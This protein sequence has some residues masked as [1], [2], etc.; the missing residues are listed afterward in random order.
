MSWIENSIVFHFSLRSS[1]E[2]LIVLVEVL[3]QDRDFIPGDLDSQNEDK[4][5]K[6]LGKEIS[7][8]LAKPIN[9]LVIKEKYEISPTVVDDKVP[10]TDKLAGTVIFTVKSELFSSI[11]KFPSYDL[12][13]KGADSQVLAGF[14]MLLRVNWKL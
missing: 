11:I 2:R 13:I 10:E 5:L 8:L 1:K 4:R 12:S 6:P 14:R 7:S 3:S 9:V